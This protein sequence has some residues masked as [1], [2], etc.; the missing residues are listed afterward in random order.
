MPKLG[1]DPVRR[2]TLVKATIAEVGAA[3]SA[4]VTVGQIA[5]RAGMSPALAHHYFGGKEQILDAATRHILRRYGAEVRQ[6]LAMATTPR[7]RIAAVVRGSFAPSN[8]HGE[9]VSA[10][11]I[12]YVRAQCLP[13][14]RRLLAVYQ[15]RLRSNLLVGLR[16]LVGARAGVVAETLAALIDGL[17]LRAALAAEPADGE[18]AATQVLGVLDCL[19]EG[20]E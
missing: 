16:P 8:F 5:R 7:A 13:E 2:D 14:A 17:Y 10:W 3:G 19:L 18:A 6:A 20:G 4:E 15:R 9:T 11:L 1:P 12:L